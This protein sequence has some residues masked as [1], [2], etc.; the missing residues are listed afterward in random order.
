MARSAA[1]APRSASPSA[2]DAGATPSASTAPEGSGAADQGGRRYVRLTG[3]G[4]YE[5]GRYL[6]AGQALE[7]GVEI[8]E[9]LAQVRLAAGEAET[10]LGSSAA[11]EAVRVA[12]GDVLARIRTNVSAV[13][14][15]AAAAGGRE[16]AEIV[17]QGLSGNL[18]DQ[19][20]ALALDEA[21]DALGIA[22]DAEAGPS[23]PPV[24]NPPPESGAA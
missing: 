24:E 16:L 14:A 9:R 2:S 8:S 15:A 22:L 1:K 12:L 20:A 21:M 7:I 11:A 10:V 3:S 23:A 17:R 6:A 18:E 19:A 4:T 13:E 5:G